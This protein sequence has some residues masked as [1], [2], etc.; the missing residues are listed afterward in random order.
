MC[1]STPLFDCFIGTR[2]CWLQQVQRTRCHSFNVGA[3]SAGSLSLWDAQ[4]M[5][6]NNVCQLAYRGT[7][8]TLFALEDHAACI[9]L[10]RSTRRSGGAATL[11]GS[12][13]RCWRPAELTS[14]GRK[15]CTASSKIIAGA[16]SCTRLVG[17]QGYQVA[18][19]V[20]A[21]AAAAAAA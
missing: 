14:T 20:T 12:G 16:A 11:A 7:S 15:P 1:R 10:L 8:I 18:M 6:T 9:R 13:V 5:Y 4:V 19:Q 17:Q 2:R 21:A 3:S